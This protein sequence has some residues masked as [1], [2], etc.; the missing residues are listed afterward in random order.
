MYFNYISDSERTQ[1]KCFMSILLKH[2]LFVTNYL[3]RRLFQ[4]FIFLIEV[5]A[6]YFL[7]VLQHFWFYESFSGNFCKARI[8]ITSNRLFLFSDFRSDFE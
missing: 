6:Q 7:E 5:A 4:I 2:R 3:K 1:S 8:K